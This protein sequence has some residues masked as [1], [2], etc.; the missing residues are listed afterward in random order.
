MQP[1]VFSCVASACLMKKKCV[2]QSLTSKCLMI[3]RGGEGANIH[4]FVFPVVLE[5]LLN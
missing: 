2:P 3:K 4:M 5:F 1:S